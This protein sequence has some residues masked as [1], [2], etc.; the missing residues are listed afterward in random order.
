ME[1]YQ[2]RAFISSTF[3]IVSISSKIMVNYNFLWSIV[4]LPFRYLICPW[5]LPIIATFTVLPVRLSRSNFF[6]L[7]C[8]A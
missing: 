4:G 5:S 6:V 8:C 1:N 2:W 7:T 3:E